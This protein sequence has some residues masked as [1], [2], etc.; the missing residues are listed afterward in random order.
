MYSFRK[1]TAADFPEIQKILDRVSLPADGV[2]AH[3]QNFLICQVAESIV[4]CGGF[5]AYFPAALLRSL[6]VLPAYQGKGI[7][8]KLINTLLEKFRIERFNQLFLLTFDAEKYF[9]RH[10]GFRVVS[11]SQAPPAIRNS[12]EFTTACPQS[13]IC[14]VKNLL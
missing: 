7:G 4:A 2:E 8:Q 6:A 11:R 10:F 1:A 12:V 3:L 13:A 9:Q 5:E 14:M